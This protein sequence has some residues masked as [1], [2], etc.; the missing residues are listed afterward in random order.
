MN[1]A[2]RL[3]RTFQRFGPLAQ[4]LDDALRTAGKA[5]D[6][7]KDERNHADRSEAIHIDP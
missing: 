1:S 4:F 2:E 3:D 6:E 7:A 5:F